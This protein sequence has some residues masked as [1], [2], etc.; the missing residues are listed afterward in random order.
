MAAKTGPRLGTSYGW[1]LGENG[2]NTGMDTNLK[3]LDTLLGG[4]TVISNA[5]TAPPASGTS[6]SAIGPADLDGA[7]TSA[8]TWKGNILTA[9]QASL[10]TSVDARINPAVGVQLQAVIVAVTRGTNGGVISGTPVFSTTVTPSSTGFQTIRFNFSSPVAVTAGS[11]Y[12][13]AIGAIGQ[14]STYQLPLSFPTTAT[15]PTNS[16]FA[17]D[18]VFR[19]AAT[20][21]ANGL[22]YDSNS[23]NSNPAIIRLNGNTGSLSE[24]D[25]YIVPSGAT[26]AWAGKT[27]QVA[28]YV[29]GAWLYIPPK[30]GMRLDVQSAGVAMRYNGTS[31]IPDYGLLSNRNVFVDGA[32]DFWSTGTSFSLAAGVNQYTADMWRSYSGAGGAAT[33]SQQAYA[34]GSNLANSPVPPK[35]FLRHQQTTAASDNPFVSQPMEGVGTFSG[36]SVTFA[37]NLK[38]AAALTIGSIV[39]LQKFGSGGSPSATVTTT[40]AVTWAVGTTE[41]RFSVRI[42]IP[43]IAGKTIGTNGDDCLEVR[44]LMPSGQTFTLDVGQFQIEQCDATASGDTTGS[45][46]APTPFEHRGPA[47]EKSRA[48]RYLYQVSCASSGLMVIVIVSATSAYSW[49]PIPP[50]RARGTAAFSGS[51]TVNG[52]FA[53]TVTPGMSSESVINVTVASSGMTPG[54]GYL[55]GT[56]T[57]TFDARL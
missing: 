32:L 31:W 9:S 39:V 7:S 52:S 30:R 42:D 28:V 23:D 49:I 3:I 38:A 22:N 21:V 24:G 2:W 53:A 5:V 4:G 47:A 6:Y 16:W 55:V 11:K 26:G 36:Q 1:T 18:T 17:M 35:Y 15:W 48:S 43:S 46:G 27:N 54:A 34:A 57:L 50:M 40:K 33:V 56:A 12:A 41:K 25:T 45:G 8:Y 20:T 19:M 29:D 51:L 37:V 10:V 14:G 13:V 44:L